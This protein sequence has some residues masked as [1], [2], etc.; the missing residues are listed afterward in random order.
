MSITSNNKLPRS[1]R[2][3]AKLAR[4]LTNLVCYPLPPPQTRNWLSYKIF[5]SLNSGTVIGSM[6]EMGRIISQAEQNLLIQNTGSVA[7]GKQFNFKGYKALM[8]VNQFLA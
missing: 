7:L 1:C 3:F 8:A 6:A 4:V 2:R 5:F